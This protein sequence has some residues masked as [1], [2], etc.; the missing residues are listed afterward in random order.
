MTLPSSSEWMKVATPFLIWAIRP[1]GVQQEA[2][3]V[4]I[5]TA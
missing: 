3:L 4:E 1:N 2:A 5:L